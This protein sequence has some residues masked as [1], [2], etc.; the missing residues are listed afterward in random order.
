VLR[1]QK[2]RAA[3]HWKSPNS[4]AEWDQSRKR[5][6]LSDGTRTVQ[7]G[8]GHS[9]SVIVHE[10]LHGYIWQNT[11]LNAHDEPGAIV[12]HVCDVFGL[13]ARQWHAD[14]NN[15]PI[16]W[17]FG[18]DVFLPGAEVQCIRNFADPRAGRDQGATTRQEI[19]SF[20][21][22][23]FA[24]GLLNHLFYKIAVDMDE[25]PWESLG[26][27]WQKTLTQI[28]PSP[29]LESFCS[30]LAAN[31]QNVDGALQHA[32]DELGLDIVG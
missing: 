19:V 25:P 20:S 8:Y 13:L 12:E 23:Y 22:K 17:L 32:M 24:A 29:T 31:A 30:V 14:K 4:N 16:D 1:P 7:R 2:I 18:A 3:I 5:V 26:P 28:G 6:L 27:V 11:R 15:Q 21:N 9:L 10:L